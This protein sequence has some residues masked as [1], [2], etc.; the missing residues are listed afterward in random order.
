M[1]DTTLDPI[2]RG[3]PRRDANRD[4]SCRRLVRSI[5][6]AAGHGDPKTPKGCAPRAHA[7][8]RFASCWPR[9]PRPLA[10]QPLDVRRNDH[11]RHSV[12][13][14]VPHRRRVH[15]QMSHA[16]RARQLPGRKG[17]ALRRDLG[18]DPLDLGNGIA[19]HCPTFDSDNRR[20][21]PFCPIRPRSRP[22]PTS[23][24]LGANFLG[25]RPS[26]SLLA[27]NPGTAR[28]LDLDPPVGPR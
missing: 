21:A 9:I 20:N 2:S 8:R 18:R 6:R 15:H 14:V 19:G 27:R 25:L 23:R 7:R 22:P 17:L 11:L 4:A 28:L 10:V 26:R 13:Q 12:A 3:G 16:F 24:R 1:P 5:E